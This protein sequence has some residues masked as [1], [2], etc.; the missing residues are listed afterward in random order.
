MYVD[1]SH[2]GLT[3]FSKD[4]ATRVAAPLRLNSP[5]LQLE[6]LADR[7]SVEVFADGGHVVLTNLVFPEQDAYDLETVSTDR[8]TTVEVEGWTLRSIWPG[9]SAR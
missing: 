4:F 5:K 6:I 9:P 7:N 8:G 1:R 3:S 2:S